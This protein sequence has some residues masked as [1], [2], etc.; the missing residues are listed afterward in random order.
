M[1]VMVWYG[2][3]RWGD[4]KVLGM[5]ISIGGR[6]F[7]CL[8]PVRGRGIS[9]LM[10]VPLHVTVPYSCNS[11]VRIDSPLPRE[12]FFFA[13]LRLIRLSYPPYLSL[14]VSGWC[15]GVAYLRNLI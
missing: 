13:L 1:G 15:R 8:A 11:T 9:Y 5:R 10:S 4:A 3:V 12:P 6:V 2:I 14:S 7:L